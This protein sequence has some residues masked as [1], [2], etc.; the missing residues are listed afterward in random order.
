MPIDPDRARRC[1]SPTIGLTL[2][3]LYVVRQVVDRLVEIRDDH[4]LVGLYWDWRFDPGPPEP[5]RLNWRM[6]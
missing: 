5:P 2:G 4:G 1:K 6:D 3:R